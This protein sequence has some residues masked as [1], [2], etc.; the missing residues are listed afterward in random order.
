MQQIAQSFFVD[1]KA[2]DFHATIFYSFYMSKLKKAK[3]THN[4]KKAIFLLV[5]RLV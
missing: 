2:F 5:K 4:G 3:M 1:C